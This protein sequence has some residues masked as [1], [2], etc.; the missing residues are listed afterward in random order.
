MGWVIHGSHGAVLG[1]G[2]AANLQAK[3]ELAS[4]P[5]RSIVAGVADGV[6]S[7]SC[8]APP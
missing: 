2:F 6:L 7:G 8:S 1:V 4:S 5:G 3:P